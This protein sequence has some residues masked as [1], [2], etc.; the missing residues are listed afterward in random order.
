MVLAPNDLFSWNNKYYKYIEYNITDTFTSF[1]LA[2]HTTY[3]V[4]AGILK[5]WRGRL[6][7]P[8]AVFSFY[9]VLSLPLSGLNWR[10]LF[11]PRGPGVPPS[12]KW[13]PHSQ[14]PRTLPYRDPEQC[15]LINSGKIELRLVYGMFFSFLRQSRCI[16]LWSSQKVQNMGQTF[17]LKK[18]NRGIKERRIVCRVQFRWKSWTK[19]YPKKDIN[20]KEKTKLSFSTFIIDHWNLFYIYLCMTFFFLE[21]F[22]RILFRLNLLQKYYF[23][24]YSTFCNFEAQYVWKDSKME[25][26]HS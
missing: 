1:F 7:W 13:R 4:H 25:N 6:P 16:Y 2:M 9:H 26:Y 21:L 12:P 10:S 19:G 23:T 8:L 24:M 22:Q 15:W 3:S 5:P 11:P 14:G 20:K 17:C 18:L